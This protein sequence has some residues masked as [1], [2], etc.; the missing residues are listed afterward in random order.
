M[1]VQALVRLRVNAH[2]L[3]P[4]NVGLWIYVHVRVIMA[5]KVNI[6]ML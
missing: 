1:H 2:S 5:A 6:M 3:K 4:L